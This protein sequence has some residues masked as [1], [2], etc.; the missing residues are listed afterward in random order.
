MN[1]ESWRKERE[2]LESILEDI[3]RGFIRLEQGQEDYVATLK[4]RIE[5]L[6]EKLIRAA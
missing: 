1:V 5:N 6:D 3:D 4:R 2:K